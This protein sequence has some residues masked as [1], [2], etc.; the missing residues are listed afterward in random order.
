MALYPPGHDEQRIPV[1]VLRRA[2]EAIFRAA[3]MKP[4]ASYLVADSVVYADRRGNHSH[5]SL[6]V[7]DYV[8]KLVYGGVNPRGEPRLIASSGPVLSVDAD[9]AMGQVGMAFAMGHA[10]DRAADVGVALAA[11]GGSNHCGALNYFS[12]MA[13]GQGMVGVCG[14]NAIPTMAPKGGRDR[15]IGLNPISIAI[16][17]GRS[18]FLLDTTF[19][20]AAYGKIRVY[21]QKG[22]PIPHGW[23]LDSEGRS[24]TDPRAAFDGLIQPIGGHK[25]V[26]LGM[27]VGMLS[28][29][30]SGAAYGTELGSL[31]RG[32]V[33]GR[34][35]HFCLAINVA[36]F[37][38]L[39][40]V[41]L[42]V[43]RILEEIRL[44]QRLGGVDRLCAPGDLGDSLDRDYSVNGIP[45]NRETLGGVRNAAQ[46][47]GASIAELD[48]VI[49]RDARTTSGA[50]HDN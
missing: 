32:A 41:R 34:D 44:G 28:T 1:E 50:S 9:N 23:V 42:R 24:T 11:V 31:A 49:A 30:L 35:G 43:D 45:L 40:A 2:L 6:H 29:L 16:P 27:A 37:Q 39:E 12:S 10:I 26:G 46:M 47:V 21:E 36:A 5:G 48:S 19:G 33:S 25:G 38:P 14:T 22:H 3:G 18:D 4:E 7:P 20:E 8:K 15:V 17:G 13:A